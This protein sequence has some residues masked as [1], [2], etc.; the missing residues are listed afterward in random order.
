MSDWQKQIRCSL[1]AEVVAIFRSYRCVWHFTGKKQFAHVKSL[2][3]A[4]CKKIN[5]YLG[6]TVFYIYPQLSRVRILK[7]IG[8]NWTEGLIFLKL[9]FVCACLGKRGTKDSTGR[10]WKALIQYCR[11]SFCAKPVGIASRM[12]YY[13]LLHQDQCVSIKII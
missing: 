11:K 5:K 13:T 8:T 3:A 6:T 4:Q 10:L 9:L 2:M 12:Y 1:N 7:W